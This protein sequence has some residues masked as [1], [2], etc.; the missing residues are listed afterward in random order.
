MDPTSRL[1]RPSGYHRANVAEFCLFSYDRLDCSSSA[2]SR[3]A[4]VPPFHL[5]HHRQ[6]ARYVQPRR[7]RRSRRQAPDRCRDS[8]RATTC[9]RAAPSAFPA[10][11]CPAGACMDPTRPD[12]TQSNRTNPAAH[13]ES[14]EPRRPEILSNRS[15][16]ARANSRAK[17]RTNPRPA[18][19]LEDMQLHSAN[20]PDTRRAQPPRDARARPLGKDRLPAAPGW[21]ASR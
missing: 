9:G 16:A 1:L 2:P 20:E 18:E 11:A 8:R 3:C 21:R 15:C 14:N 17:N 6:E 4:A 7:S 10:P 13:Q 5:D 12:P 19:I